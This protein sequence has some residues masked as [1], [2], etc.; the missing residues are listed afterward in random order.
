MEIKETTAITGIGMLTP[1]GGNKNTFWKQLG[2]GSSGIK[3]ITLFDASR[4]SCQRAGEI[5]DFDPGQYLGQKGLRYLSRT[6]KLLMSTAYMS[7]LDAGIKNE[8]REYL[9]Y[10]GQS[11]G[12]VVGTTYGSFS[13][14]CSFDTISLLEGPQAAS[15]MAFPNTVINCHAGYLAI[16]ESLQGP[17]ITVSTGYAASIDAIG[18]AV[19]YL[20][21]DGMKCFIVGGVE[22]LSEEFFLSY[23]KQG[24]L[25]RDSCI[26]EGCGIFVIERLGDAIS[27]SAHIYGQIAGYGN[28]CCEGG[29]ALGLA[30]DFAIEEAQIN[31]NQ[32]DLVVGGLNLSE[33]EKA[34]EAETLSSKFGSD[35][36]ALDFRSALGDCYSAGG[37]LQVGAALGIINQSSVNNALVVATDPSGNCSALV[38]KRFVG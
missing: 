13:S 16:K 11:I 5:S 23:L 38:I 32:I 14:I 24:L 35:I 28:A 6:S 18:I 26:A 21:S 30:I 1:F 34:L 17:S 8:Q 9:C 37:S 31:K 4:Y 19:Q 29:N 33:R 7:L 20:E 22:E 10:D 25:S 36:R 15:P 27:R 12:I 2:N 3:E